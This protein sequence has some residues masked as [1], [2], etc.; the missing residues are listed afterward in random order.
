M[1]IKKQFLWSMLPLL[2]ISVV[3]LF[4]VPFFLHYLG[5][6]MYAIW[7]YVI[8][9]TATF[10]FRTWAWVWRWGDTSVWHWAK[11]MRQRC[12]NIGH[13]EFDR[14]SVA[15]FNGAGVCRTGCMDRPHGLDKLKPENVPVLRWAFV[16]GGCG[17]FLSYY[18]QFW[19]MLSQAHLDFKF[20]GILGGCFS[21]LQVLLA[22][23]LAYLTHNP[24][25]IILSGVGFGILQLGM[26]VWHAVRHYHLGL[27]LHEAK[28]ARAREM[29]HYTAKTF[30]TL[31]AGSFL[32][33][34][35]RLLVGKF[36]P[37]AFVHYY[38]C[39]V[40]ARAFRV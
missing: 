2:I 11:A 37:I 6:E 8:A 13:G 22:M 23:W 19:Q 27:N 1:N 9:S 26:F 18:I 4:S 34:I 15:G 16:F 20:I 14:D 28:L 30:A 40:L 29:S 35:D 3:N 36:D 10:G 17:L 33:S 32:G 12:G 24:V 7:L 39:I 21:V 38:I 25:V 31:L 5:K